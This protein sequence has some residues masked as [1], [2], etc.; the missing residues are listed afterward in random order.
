MSVDVA[1]RTYAKCVALVHDQAF[2]TARHLNHDV[3][4]ERTFP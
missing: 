4:S 2:G 1:T 3:Y